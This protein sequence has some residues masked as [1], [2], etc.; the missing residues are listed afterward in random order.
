M[1]ER[2]RA[3]AEPDSKP[4]KPAEGP[5]R[6]VQRAPRPGGGDV[7]W[8]ELA[9]RLRALAPAA[10]PAATTVVDEAVARMRER[11]ADAEAEYRRARSALGR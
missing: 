2:E 9:R 11:P 7:E 3:A 10:D 5:P 6:D 1:A 8:E 4:A